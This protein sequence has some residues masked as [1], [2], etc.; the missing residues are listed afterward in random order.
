MVHDIVIGRRACLRL[1]TRRPIWS[2]LHDEPAALFI[3]E[4][5]LRD[6]RQ[7]GLLPG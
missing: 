7:F 6:S 1:P 3:I 4:V 2:L 5:K